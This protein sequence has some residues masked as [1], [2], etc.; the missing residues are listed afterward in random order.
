MGRNKRYDKLT[1]A[2]HI[3][4]HT[5]GTSNELSFSVLDAAKN[6]LGVDIDD[7]RQ[8]PSPFGRISLFTLPFRGKK[9]VTT[10][11]KEGGLPLSNGSFASAEDSS[12]LRGGGRGDGGYGNATMPP[13]GLGG[14]QSTSAHPGS[15]S[16]QVD[17]FEQEG[18][19]SPSSRARA[20]TPFTGSSHAAE[21][22]IVQRKRRRRRQRRLAAAFVA[23]VTTSLVAAGGTYLYQDNQRHLSQVSQLDEVLSSVADMDAVFMSLDEAVADPFGASAEGE[24]EELSSSVPPVARELRDIDV[25]LQSASADMHESMDKEAATQAFA[26]IAARQILADKGMQLLDQAADAREAAD[27]LDK[28]WKQVLEADSLARDAAELVTDT[29]DEHIQA[30]KEKTNQALAAFSEARDMLEEAQGQYASADLSLLISYVDKRIESLG[31]AVASDDAFL[32]RDKEGAAAQNDA[33]NDADAEAVALAKEI[34]SDPA[35]LV[36][37]G[38]EQAVSDISQAYSTARLQAGSA[39]AFIRDYLGR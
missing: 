31:Y 26:T 14:S 35:E 7:K 12:S 24:Y 18:T 11:H 39:D 9:P 23:V 17:G 22:E 8:N 21:E 1:R 25:R 5:V 38:Y 34:P 30:S 28:A 2:A 13:G 15:T 19:H 16:G 20:N 37:E 33:Y 29:T 10:P 6:Q 27:R 36:H 4:R 3:K 32:S